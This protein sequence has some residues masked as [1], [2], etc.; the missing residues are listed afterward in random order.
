MGN[1]FFQLNKNLHLHT[2]DEYGSMPVM[3]GDYTLISE[4][5][6]VLSDVMNNALLAYSKVFAFRFDLR[7]PVEVDASHQNFDNAVV[8]KFVES[9]KAKIRHNRMAVRARCTQVHDTTVRY[10]WVRELGMQGRVH[11]HFVVL[12][13]GH[14]Y[15]RLGNY[16][17]MQ[18]NMAS[19]ICEAW[20]S[21]L[22]VTVESA[23]CLVHFP[24]N[25]SY[26]LWRSQQES[27][28]AFFYRASYLCK[29]STKHHGF[30]H[31]SHGASR[32]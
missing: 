21:A 23:R 22:G 28:D 4:Y 20:A 10:F 17:N 8:S 24:E 1:Y 13:N 11:Y 15:N 6:A 27:I 12:L 18:D 31:H 3:S 14:A 25:P 32:G 29:A 26:T 16:K 30:G 2:G 9:F 5:L 19:R 7:L